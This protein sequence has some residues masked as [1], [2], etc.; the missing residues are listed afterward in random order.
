MLN[1]YTDTDFEKFVKLKI[2][3]AKLIPEMHVP[4]PYAI[5]SYEA[6]SNIE[7]EIDSLKKQLDDAVRVIEFYSNEHNWSRAFGKSG[8]SI[9]SI[10]ISD[11]DFIGINGDCRQGGKK[12]REFL[13]RMKN[14]T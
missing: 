10:N 6:F 1:M 3:N 9:T 5:C 4:N 12:A 14:E 11:Q 8:E 13:K 7:K 2:R